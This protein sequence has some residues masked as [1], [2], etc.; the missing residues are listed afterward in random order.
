MG[1][2]LPNSGLIVEVPEA[3][4]A[5]RH[6]RD[7]LD[8]N[9]QG[10]VPAHITVLYP[11]LP[12]HLIDGTVLDDLAALFARVPSF[13]V[14]F[15]HTAWFGEQVLWLAPEDPL[16]FRALTELVHGAYPEYP[17]FAGL[18]ADVVP[19]LTIGH[20]VH[21]PEMVRAESEV[22]THLP[23]LM[24]ARRVTLMTQDEPEG[25]WTTAARFA[26]GPHLDRAGAAEP[27]RTTVAP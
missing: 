13:D 15:T 6:H 21:L 11:F 4:T 26:L 17:P 27:R 2:L 22:R 16:P 20:G 3:E 8:V 19:H 5:V 9:A 14:A 24:S 25:V 10:G 12:P 7:A 18:F 23:I 1:A